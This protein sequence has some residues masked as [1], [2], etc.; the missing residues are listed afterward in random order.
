MIL[1]LVPLRILEEIFEKEFLPSVLM[2]HSP[3]NYL[4]YYCHSVF[5]DQQLLL[6]CAFSLI[7]RT[8][9]PNHYMSL[10]SLLQV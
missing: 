5:Q 9:I 3:G 1:L 2:I 4:Y 7:C 6:V 10:S 8:T